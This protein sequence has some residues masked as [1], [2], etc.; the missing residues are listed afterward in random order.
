MA[1]FLRNLKDIEQELI[2]E[3]DTGQED[4]TTLS[5][6]SNASRSQVLVWSRQHN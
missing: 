3:S 4:A 5:C 2:L 1:Q 6:D